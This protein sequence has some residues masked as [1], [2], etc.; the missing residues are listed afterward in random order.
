M[1][2]GLSAHLMT[3][4]KNFWVDV[5]MNHKW[6]KEWSLPNDISK[7]PKFVQCTKFD[8]KTCASKSHLLTI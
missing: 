2:Q 8:P 3:K 4:Q 7:I 1:S 6:Y 5:P